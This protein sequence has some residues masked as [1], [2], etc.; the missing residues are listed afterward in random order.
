MATDGKD[1]EQ[2]SEA[3][4]E[5]VQGGANDGLGPETPPGESTPASDLGAGVQ[6]GSAPG[7]PPTSGPPSG[8]RRRGP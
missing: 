2:L 6:A 4:L 7:A 1:S 5:A 3:E 8:A